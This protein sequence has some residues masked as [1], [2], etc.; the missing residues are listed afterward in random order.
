MKDKDSIF[1]EKLKKELFN[2]V[3][4]V[5][6]DINE[7]FD[8]ALDK[9][10][11]SKKYK[12]RKLIIS[13]SAASLACFILIGVTM[14]TYASKLPIIGSIFEA[15]NSLRYKN[16]DE[17]ASDINITKE[18]NGVKITIGK[19]IYDGIN[20]D[21]FY[22]IESTEPMNTATYF[23]DN[24]IKINGNKTSFSSSSSGK[25]LDDNKT[26]VGTISYSVNSNDY[27][28]KELQEEN[29][30]GGY[31]EV[32]D[33][34]MLSLQI[35]KVGDFSDEND[36]NYVSG[37]WNFEIPISNSKLKD[38]V[39]EK[40]INISLDNINP[41]TAI[42]KII[43]T[44]INTAIQG[45]SRYDYGNNID[46]MVF[47]DKGRY[48]EGKSSDGFGVGDTD[49]TY[50][51][52]FSNNFKEVYSD[53]S[54]LTFIPYEIIRYNIDENNIKTQNG[55]A[56]IKLETPI[57]LQ[58][59]TSLKTYNGDDYGTITRIES[60]DGITKVYY[61][62]N[63]VLL[64]APREIHN[65]TTGEI[66]KNSDN[67]DYMQLENTRYIHETGEVVVEFN[68][69]LVGDNYS[70]SYYDHSVT[71]KFYL[72]EIFNIDISNK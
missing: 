62:S 1:D 70:I 57:N 7:V 56:P 28:P 54:S 4:S 69:E 41:Q 5:P 66:I 21:I 9:V 52:Y 36:M 47:D 17:Y 3:N 14:P 20:L 16:Y 39:I 31:V 15:F 26:Y 49:A 6:R 72:N 33:E 29:L 37:N 48:L 32:P 25:I 50:Q 12:K 34:F 61:K 63:Y 19:V 65:I 42:K 38:E 2:K 35:S 24:E 55:N 30:Y 58:G 10:I 18:S 22:T 40:D 27:I 23:L 64:A 51:Y 53:S 11:K 43:T 45:V 13:I 60:L 46:F 67:F 68:T 71:E 44:P 8:T 59:E